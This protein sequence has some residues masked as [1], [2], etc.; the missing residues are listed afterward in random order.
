MRRIAPALL[1]AVAGIGAGCGAT[2]HSAQTA[3][4][5]HDR[6]IFTSSCA[7]CHTL[8]GRESGAPG[9]DLAL[10]HLSVADLASFARIMPTPSRLSQAEALAVAEYVHAVAG[11]R[12]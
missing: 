7:S 4:T 12:R 8:A 6:A 10:A 3:Q 1:L 5:R 2:Q 9:G 11:S